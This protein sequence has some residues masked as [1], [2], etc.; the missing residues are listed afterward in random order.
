MAAREAEIPGSEP[1]LVSDVL[2]SVKLIR[3]GSGDLQARVQKAQVVNL[4]VV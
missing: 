1:H 3:K 4:V 2:E